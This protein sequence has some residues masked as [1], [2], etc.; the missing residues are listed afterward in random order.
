[1]LMWVVLGHARRDAAAAKK[2]EG[3]PDAG[4]KKHK[5][6]GSGSRALKL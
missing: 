4:K 6:F 3:R 1:M 2:A 5:E